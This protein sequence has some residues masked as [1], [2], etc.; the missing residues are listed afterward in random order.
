MNS[1]DHDMIKKDTVKSGVLHCCCSAAV[2]PLI[3]LPL[4]T[5]ITAVYYLPPTLWS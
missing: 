2:L 4:I 5:A 3:I 1:Q